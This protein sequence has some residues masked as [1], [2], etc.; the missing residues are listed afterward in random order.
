MPSVANES[1]SDQSLYADV[2]ARLAEARALLEEVDLA[3]ASRLAIESRLTK[4]ERTA[5]SDL[6]HASRDLDDVLFPLR[7]GVEPGPPRDD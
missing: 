4:V 1:A 3:D 6:T 7:R 2:L 5:R